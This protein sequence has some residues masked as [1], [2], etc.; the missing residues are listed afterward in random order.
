M[1]TRPNLKYRIGLGDWDA[2]TPQWRANLDAWAAR[3]HYDVVIDLTDLGPMNDHVRDIE[4]LDRD[5]LEN[6]DSDYTT[7]PRQSGGG[8]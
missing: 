4:M 7:W 1:S 3:N 8:I 5:K 6:G 2:A